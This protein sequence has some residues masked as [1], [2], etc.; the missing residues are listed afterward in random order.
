MISA[1]LLPSSAAAS[2][3]C[4]HVS[5]RIGTRA[6]WVNSRPG[7]RPG[8]RFSEGVSLAIKTLEQDSFD[9]Y[10]NIFY[11]THAFKREILK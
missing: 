1:A 2:V 7:G 9:S 6:M 5:A 3:S 4:C 11:Q 8:G 10:I